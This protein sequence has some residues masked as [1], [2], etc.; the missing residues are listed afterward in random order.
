MSVTSVTPMTGLPVVAVQTLFGVDVSILVLAAGILLVVAAGV[1]VFV[2]RRAVAQARQQAEEAELAAQQANAIKNDFVAMVSHELRTPLTSIAGFAETLRESW[3]T[4]QP[5]EVDEFLNI[6]G[7]QAAY[8]GEL[9]EDVLVIPRL[10]AGRLRLYPETFDLGKLVHDVS[11]LLFPPGQGREASVSIPAGVR[12]HADP[13]RTQQVI[14]NLLENARKYGGDQ[15]LVEGFPYGDHYVVV[16][17]DNGSGVPDD[18]V[19][20]IFEHFEQ[21]SKGDSRSAS[22]IGLGL[23]IARKLARAMGGDVWY[24]RRF[25]TGSRFCFSLTITEAAAERIQAERRA[26]EEA[27]AEASSS[28]R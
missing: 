25:P 19:N 23:P 11:D 1:A 13:R 2:S 20:L 14:R 16:V 15:V 17:S 9:V 7:K 27:E 5:D 28:R 6:I 21:L 12:V 10:Q 4:L 8:L 22:G 3:Q 24:E 18:A 26:A